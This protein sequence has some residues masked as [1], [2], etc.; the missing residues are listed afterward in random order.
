[1]K[2]IFIFCQS[3]IQ[4]QSRFDHETTIVESR[5]FDK[6][7]IFYVTDYFS[8]FIISYKTKRLYEIRSE[9]DIKIFED[10]LNILF[11]TNYVN[12]NLNFPKY[13]MELEILN[14]K[15]S[16]MPETQEFIYNIEN[17]PLLFNYIGL[18]RPKLIALV[19][20][21]E[22]LQLN[23]NELLCILHK[24]HDKFLEPNIQNQ[25]CWDR[26]SF[27]LLKHLKPSI[28]RTNYQ[29]R[30][31]ECHLCV[32]GETILI[33]KNSDSFY[34]IGT[35]KMYLPLSIKEVMLNHFKVIKKE[36]IVLKGI[37]KEEIHKISDIL[38][39]K[40]IKLSEIE[41]LLEFLL[42]L[43]VI[44]MKTVNFKSYLIEKFDL[45]NQRSALII[46]KDI[47]DWIFPFNFELNTLLKQIERILTE[48]NFIEM[49]YKNLLSLIESKEYNINN[50]FKLKYKMNVIDEY[51]NKRREL[52]KS[53]KKHLKF[54]KSKSRDLMW[55][56]LK[57]DFHSINLK[58]SDLTYL[59][60]ISIDNGFGLHCFYDAIVNLYISLKEN[61]ED[62]V[63][64]SNS[65]LQHNSFSHVNKSLQKISKL[66]NKKYL[67]PIDFYY[68]QWLGNEIDECFI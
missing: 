25:K 28:S 44:K 32:I 34:K 10:F 56:L 8:Y 64:D 19:N 66:L 29:I 38:F 52:L 57:S 5:F 40:S 24:L 12:G 60:I 49:L 15:Y 22:C 41:E 53:I 35:S 59:S 23:Y 27:L 45:M 13:N 33:L 61:F 50:Y 4:T 58:S 11:T 31:L 37:L 39:N 47:Y 3:I 67:L 18:L 30:N 42:N 48:N 43:Q 7:S 46:E 20:L 36:L 68:D 55:K 54:G 9:E 26:S 62:L 16:L 6:N 1:M 21:V 2:I 51:K 65:V 14:S 63:T 17:D